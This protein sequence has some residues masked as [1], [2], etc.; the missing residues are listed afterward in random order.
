MESLNNKD[1]FKNTGYCKVSK[2]FDQKFLDIITQYVFF[3]QMKEENSKFYGDPQAMYAYSKYGDPLM[4]TI[5]LELRHIIEKNT[6]YSLHPT[7]SYYRMYYDGDDLEIHTDRESCEISATLCI[8]YEYI[9]SN[10]S[11]PIVMDG[12]SIVLEPGDLVIYKGCELPHYRDKL[13]TGSDESWHLQGFFH[14]VDQDGPYSS[15][16][17]DKR[18]TLGKKS[19][20]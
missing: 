15:W 1:I 12:N 9:P 7:Y 4:E 8:N 10:Y 14:F 3:D 5:L 16:K 17:F 19:V 20:I 2:V 18:E 13:H 6:G 11:W